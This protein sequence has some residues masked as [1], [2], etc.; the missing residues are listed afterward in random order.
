MKDKR[1]MKVTALITAVVSVINIFSP[2]CSD[3]R[4]LFNQIYAG[5]VDEDEGIVT[6]EETTETTVTE[7]M[8]SETTV[9]ET[10]LPETTVPET[11]VPETTVSET[12]VPETT[13]SET[14][15]SDTTVSET[16][17]PET[18]LPETT[19]SETSLW[20]TSISETTASE[21][22]VSE[23]TVSETTASEE[24]SE[25]LETE[26]TEEIEIEEVILEEAEAELLAG[27]DIITINSSIDLINYS[28]AYSLDPASY[29]NTDVYIAITS[30]DL[31]DLS[32]FISIGTP[33]YPFAAKLNIA[34]STDLSI[35][36][37]KPLFAYIKDSAQI[38][39]SQG[40]A[41]TVTIA[42]STPADSALF[43]ENV[44]HDS[45][46]SAP[47]VWKVDIGVYTDSSGVLNNYSF[48]SLIGTLGKDSAV[49][50][51]ISNGHTSAASIVS[52][53]DAG[54]ACG[55]MEQ[56]TSLSVNL[57]GINIAYSVT[58]SGGNAGGMVGTMESGSALSL[59]S[60]SALTADVTSG[61]YAGGFAGYAEN[62]SV[63]FDGFSKV[64]GI[65]SGGL[66]T[67]GIFGYYRNTEENNSI[68]ISKY[69]VSC[70]L[71]GSNSGGIFGRL[72]NGGNII[73]SDSASGNISL[74]K[75]ASDN[76]DYGG[77]IGTYISDSSYNSLTVS[78]ISVNMANSSG[79]ADNYGGFIGRADDDS[80]IRFENVSVSAN[81]C[82][83][84]V[85][86]FGGLVGFVGKAF[87]DA[88]NITIGTNGN[89]RGGGVAGNMS[90]GILRLSG[91]TDISGTYT[92]QGGQ[93]VGTRGNRAV[94]YAEN[95]WKLI[96][97]SEAVGFD[98]IGSW[99]SVLRLVPSLNESD[100]FTV[101]DT[102]HTVTV[103]GAGTS[104]DSLADFVKLALNIQMNNGTASEGL[105]CFE[106]T[107]NTSG[108]LLSSDISVNCDI[109]LTGTGLTG[110]T[111]DDGNN[112]IY[113]GTFNG[114]G[115][116]ITLADGEPY[117]Y[118]GNDSSPITADDTTEGNGCIHRHYY[119]ALFAR[120]GNG[121][122][123][124]DVKING[125]VNVSYKD[126]VKYY[127]G[128]AAGQHTKGEFTAENVTAAE[129][130]RLAG[131]GGEY[132]FTGG[133]AGNIA[134]NADPTIVIR[135]CVISPEIAY[136]HN[137]SKF[138]C[139]GAFGEITSTANFDIT[140]ENVQLGASVTSLSTSQNGKKGGFIGNISNYRNTSGTRTLSI[141]NMTIDGAEIESVSGGALLGEAWNDTEV[142]IG[143]E[144]EKG[145]TVKNASVSQTGNDGFAGLV[146][147]AT[148]Y[149]KVYDVNISS[150]IVNGGSASSFG[151]FVNKGVKEDNTKKI[152]LY[153]EFEKEDAYNIASADL[154]GLNS[155]A[156][157]D[158]IIAT[159]S[160]SCGTDDTVLQNDKCAVVSI[161]TSGDAVIMDGTSCN[162]YQNKTSV[163]RAN[164][165]SRYYYNLDVIRAKNA[166]ELNSSEKLMLWSVNKYAYSNIKQYFPDMLNNTI[167]AGTY[168]MTG[169][170]YYP[171]DMPEAMTVEGGST[172]TFCSNEIESGESGTG[173]TDNMARTAVGEFTQHYL[174]HCGLFRN[175]GKSLNTGSSIT[176]RGSAGGNT[177]YSG[178]LVCGTFKGSTVET[179][180]VN[181]D[182]IL[183]DGICINGNTSQTGYAPLLIN[184]ID[185]FTDFS[186]SNVSTSERYR[187]NGTTI[188]ATSL[189]GDVGNSDATSS[190]IKLSFA[191]LTLDGRKSAI[192]DITANSSLNSAYKTDRSVFSKDVLLNSFKF[193]TGSNCSGAYNFTYN[194]DWNVDSTAKHN[195][196]YGSE[197]SD[198]A[199][200]NGLQERYLKSDTY[201]D[202][203]RPDPDSEYTFI[204][205]FLPY[206][207]AAYSSADNFHEI[208]VNQSVRAELDIGCGTYNDPYII[209][210]GRQLELLDKV[211]SGNLGVSE[212]GAVINYQKD[213]YKV[214]CAEKV[215]H[216]SLTWDSA[217]GQFV[218]EN[219]TFSVSL[220]QMQ[221]ELSNAY[222]KLSEDISIS[223][224]Y[225]GI[226]KKVPFKGVI[227]GSNKTIETGSTNPLI[228]QSKGAV[229]KDLTLK[230]NADFTGKFSTDA[231]AKYETDS[232]GTTA[233]YGGLIG[234]VNGGDNIID[235]VGITF[236]NSSTINIKNG[237]CNVTFNLALDDA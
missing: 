118:R 209:S 145:I 112:D 5:A 195:V 156:V 234:I 45:T 78:G 105:L 136:L 16:T 10:T 213:N 81:G 182:G 235:N 11:T 226:G 17:V 69:D 175:A 100:V 236:T 63:S 146:T 198:S 41:A 188:A 30:G 192:S 162:T 138:V 92:A 122:R 111:R 15:V 174:M 123:F 189:I 126:N 3:S 42:R 120:T 86:S 177:S 51:T 160:E 149:W 66:G 4:I 108:V 77:I 219:G 155:N 57:S 36:L 75:T 62:A 60:A 157:Y 27:S 132:I 19:V 35:T 90:S 168:D 130:I 94:I 110:L 8:V 131:T 154:S 179:I 79:N 147:A 18:T 166:S 46:A 29:Q 225:N 68:D 128:G 170:S 224:E 24:I 56:G 91:T 217:G 96:R 107:S 142:T 153:L 171:I 193:K 67:G 140:V 99:G 139:G 25:T 152:A 73:I 223:S 34:S 163:N 164:P 88:E 85:K 178:A 227:C 26:I 212:D 28:I 197:I 116:T 82:G 109:D 52:S 205:N 64:S 83:T 199:E 237:S 115:H 204:T 103:K 121:V 185:S 104:V 97:S 216:Q 228:Y 210:Y 72:E 125:I 61:K 214:W 87:I 207:A 23:T 206:V 158:D 143:S 220:T 89:Y 167:S 190:D 191:G 33:E 44:I 12:T 181:I 48:S 203:T 144:T 93:I 39:D 233:F 98:D 134:E 211:L 230:V 117:G 31:S 165:N 84:G 194:E 184:R 202:P 200:Y 53:G 150:I 133:I 137:N 59:T 21:T 229:V 201:T 124:S 65:I 32:G 80:Y 172:F 231:S 49:E 196:A 176:F 186:L 43:A 2:I 74:E 58:S 55:R 37:D 113:T 161:H 135:D 13:V 187:A 70:T 151:M 218:S 114:S 22:T 183:L 101:D 102:A 9:S 141:K 106:N 232:N 221:N 180:N 159:C 20:E 208:K 173:N 50:L 119:N 129:N 1:K 7:T 215:G 127:I 169:Y 95:G 54:L 148:G 47:A 40:N 14:T 38:L 76:V 6:T 71:N 222:F